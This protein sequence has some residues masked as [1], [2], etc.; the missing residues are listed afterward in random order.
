[1]LKDALAG[2]PLGQ[3]DIIADVP[4]FVIP[5][6][7]QLKIQGE[8]G[9]SKCRAEDAES[10][11]RAKEKAAGRPVVAADL[12]VVIEP[13]V[14]ITQDCDIEHK[15][16]MTVAR[17]FKLESVV[18]DARDAVKYD[19]PCVLWDVKRSITEGTD[20]ASFIYLGRPIGDAAVVADLLKVQSFAKD[21]WG[22]YFL[23][24]R[25]KCLTDD[26][27]KYLQGRLATF[28]GRYATEAGFWYE[29]GDQELATKVKG[30]KYLIDKAYDS[31]KSKRTGAPMPSPPRADPTAS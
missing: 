7:L 22:A 8:Q 14:I 30:D 21:P 31:L 3:G 16:Y 6:T 29:A 10:F 25:V 18:V 4:F 2:R 12:P 20:H 19:E 17:I 23:Q 24:N 15:S 27:A 9:Q 28:V 11:R 1:M 13:G 26:G 5:R